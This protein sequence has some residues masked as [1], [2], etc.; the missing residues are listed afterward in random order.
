[1]SAPSPDSTR[2]G[3]DGA[4]TLLGLPPGDLTISASHDEFAK[5]S[6]SQLVAGPGEQL[7]DLVLRLSEGGSIEGICFDDDGRTASN[8][9]VTVQSMAM[10]SQRVVASDSDGTF[11]IDG[12]EAGTYQVVAIDPAMRTSGDA[13]TSSINDM[14]KYTKLATAEVVEGEV[15][16][17]F[18]GAPPSDPVEVS[19]RVT[20]GGAPYAQAM[21]N[22]LPASTGV[23]EKMKF[24]T[25]DAERYS[26]TLDEAG[27]YV[28]SVAKLPGGQRSRCGRVRGAGRRG[29]R[30]PRRDFESQGTWPAAS[31]ART[32]T[33]VP[34]GSP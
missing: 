16:T 13:D 34:P 4:F 11:R 26:L 20:Q 8:R 32:A 27:D 10:T 17:V 14:F 29:H 2:S 7:D 12:L 22:W 25:T 1:M 9:I 28:I 30:D 31:S 3:A 5:A 33:S 24:T 6:A 21:V 19:G 23:Q 15:A 18:L